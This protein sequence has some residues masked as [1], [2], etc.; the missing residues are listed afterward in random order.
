[1]DAEVKKLYDAVPTLC[2]QNVSLNILLSE[3]SDINDG[4]KKELNTQFPKGYYNSAYHTRI[5][6]RIMFNKIICIKQ[7]L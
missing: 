5:F 2:K 4:I 6:K 1:M 7:L 3:K